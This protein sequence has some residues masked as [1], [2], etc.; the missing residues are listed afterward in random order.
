MGSSN[1]AARS[2]RATFHKRH[3]LPLLPPPFRGD[4]QGLGVTISLRPH[5]LPPPT[6]RFRGESRR[7]VID[8][9]THPSLVLADI[10]HTIGDGF[11]QVFI[12]EVVN[13][14]LLGLAFWQPFPSSVLEFADQFLLLR[15][16][17]DHRLTSLLKLGHAGVDVLELRVAVRMIA[18]LL[19]L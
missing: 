12:N 1:W 17:G 16:H 18:A 15:V 14:H 4:Q 11:A 2:C 8:P 5:L 9:Y 13:Q 7:V 19:R 6:N 10:V 3:R